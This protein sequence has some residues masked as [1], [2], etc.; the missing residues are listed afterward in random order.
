MQKLINRK[1]AE[2]VEMNRKVFPVTAILGPRQCGKS[3]LVKMLSRKID[4][5][6][7]LDLQNMEDVNK[8][9]D[10]RLFFRNNEDSVICL[11]EIQQMPEL[12]S[13]L[14]SIIDSNRQ[15]GRFIILGSASPQLIQ[16]SSETLAGRIG[17]VELTPFLVSELIV[18]DVKSYSMNEYVSRGGFPESYLA[19]NDEASRLWRENFI[20]TYIERDLPQIGVQLP[21]LQIRRLL[22]MFSH[23][24]GQLFNSNKLAAS[25]GVTHPTIRR[26]LDLFEQTFLVRSLEPYIINVKK[27]LIKSPKVYIRDSGLL[28]QL[29][30]I[31]DF[32]Q[33]LGHPVFGSSWEGIVIE[34]VIAE[35]PEWQPY[36]YRTATG[37][38]ID[39]VMVKGDRKIAIECK[40][41][42]APQLTKG[43][44]TVIDDIQPEHVWVVAPI[45][46]SYPIKENVTVCGLSQIVQEVKNI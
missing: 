4:S 22:T 28:H 13:D 17:F 46:D 25:M 31:S 32:N 42:T 21:S 45:N 18:N 29:L 9:S 8:L 24:Q 30:Q 5:L 39:L 27:R 7:Y 12:F 33:L 37:D 10:T 6:V 15:K 26:Y 40:A 43:F 36:F 38:E 3:T 34:N 23:L 19:E 20:R 2:V 41:S 1:Y 16:S 11:D 35:M 44:W 14:R